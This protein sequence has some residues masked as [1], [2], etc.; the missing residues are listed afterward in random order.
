MFLTKLNVCLI[1]I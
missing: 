1:Q